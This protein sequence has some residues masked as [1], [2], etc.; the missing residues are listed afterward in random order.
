MS[1]DHIHPE[2]QTFVRKYIFSIDHKI[3]GIQYMI[4]GLVF[5]VLAGLLA[6]VIRTQLMHANGG[7]VDANTYNEI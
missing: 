7:V 3:I 5:F 4:T 1:Q 6:E 2:P